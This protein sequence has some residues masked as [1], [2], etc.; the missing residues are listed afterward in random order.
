M[1]TTIHPKNLRT[2][3]PTQCW[4]IITKS[5]DVEHLSQVAEFSIRTVQPLQILF[6]TNPYFDNC[7]YTLYALFVKTWRHVL[8]KTLWCYAWESSYTLRCKTTFP[9]TGLPG[10]ARIL[11]SEL[12]SEA[13][14]SGS[15]LFAQTILSVNT[16]SCFDTYLDTSPTPVVHEVY[17]WRHIR[18]W[19]ET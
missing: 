11:L 5:S 2:N 18:C 17:R 10:Y 12:P 19:R 9:C 1:A 16:L 4:S 14:W 13:V 7:I 3:S 6:L 8:R 15:T